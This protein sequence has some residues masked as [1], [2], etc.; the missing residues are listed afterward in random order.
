MKEDKLGVHKEVNK[1]EE[2]MD[3]LECFELMKN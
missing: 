1:T 3:F 2:I